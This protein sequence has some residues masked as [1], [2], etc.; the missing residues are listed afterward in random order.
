MNNS[1]NERLKYIR[2]EL[3][4]LTQNE[5]GNK[6][7][8]K[9]STISDIEKGR[10]VLTKRNLKSICENFNINMDWLLTGNGDILKSTENDDLLTTAIANAINEND[11]FIQKF[12]ITYDN[13]SEV[14]K[15]IIKNF[16]QDLASSAK[17]KSEDEDE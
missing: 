5:F 4:K 1:T 14:G 17:L 15:N 6:I 13:L 11:E 16:I 9:G 7:G 3:L 10:R 2:K 12:I 8:I